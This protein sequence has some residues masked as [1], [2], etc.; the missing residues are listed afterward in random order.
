MR[1]CLRLLAIRVAP[2]TS[3]M[4][5][6]LVAD[7]TSA[8][9]LRIDGRVAEGPYFPMC[10]TAEPRLHAFGRYWHK[11]DMPVQ[12]PYVYRWWN[13]VAKVETRIPLSR[14][15]ELIRCVLASD[16]DRRP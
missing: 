14:A 10:D 13:P 16:E 11:T 12:S 6:P 8:A 7:R 15:G 5:F 3:F 9:R 1:C 2:S 4:D